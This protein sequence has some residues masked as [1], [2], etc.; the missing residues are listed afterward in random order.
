MMTQER[1]I[2]RTDSQRMKGETK[3]KKIL[4]LVLALALVICASFALAEEEKV[5]TKEEFDQA[6]IDDPVC[7]EAYVQANQ[8]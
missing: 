3:M 6:A 8:S 5:M 7:V 2:R 4:A 1:R